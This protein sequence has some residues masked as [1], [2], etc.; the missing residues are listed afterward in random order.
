M[1]NAVFFCRS[2]FV[3]KPVQRLIFNPLRSEE[4]G[5]IGDCGGKR[6]ASCACASCL[7]GAGS[8]TA[9]AA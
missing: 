7:G 9:V 8:V 6:Q 5:G 3:L 2:E 1:L 4:G